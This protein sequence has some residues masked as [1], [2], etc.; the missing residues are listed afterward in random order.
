MCLASWHG[1]M[2]LSMLLSWSFA[3]A[4]AVPIDVVGSGAIPVGVLVNDLV[5]V[6]DDPVFLRDIATIETH[7]RVL[8]EQLGAL[9]IGQAPK[10]GH[11]QRISGKWVHSLV[12]MGMAPNTTLTSDIPDIIT[13]KRTYQSISDDRLY[14]ILSDYLNA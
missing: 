7:D 10:P 1:V 14:A 13:V 5:M 8:K 11:E 2:V 3:H 12:E 4:A 9:K 6:N